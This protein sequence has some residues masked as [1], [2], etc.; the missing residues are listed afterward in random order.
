MKQAS[1]KSIQDAAGLEQSQQALLQKHHYLFDVQTNNI[2]TALEVTY[3]EW[4]HRIHKE[5]KNRLDCHIPVQNMMRQKKQ[6][7]MINRVE[8]HV[9][10]RYLHSRKCR[11]KAAADSPDTASSV[12]APL[13]RQLHA[14]DWLNGN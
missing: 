3:Q 11:S 1:I 8:K 12:N 10:Q 5:V 7:R 2:A 9:G 14:V 4:L 6:E 13:L